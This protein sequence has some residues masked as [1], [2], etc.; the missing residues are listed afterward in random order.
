MAKASS[1]PT[2]VR[3]PTRREIQIRAYSDDIFA[4]ALRAKDDLGLTLGDTL[5]MIVRAMAKF[6]DDTHRGSVDDGRAG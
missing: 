4:I 1:K 3:T 2:A 6:G 5:A